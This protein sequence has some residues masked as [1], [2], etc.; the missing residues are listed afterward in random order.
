[1]RVGAWLLVVVASVVASAASCDGP[2]V[3]APSP[4]QP[5]GCITDVSP[6]AHNFTCEG[7]P[8]DVFVPDACQRPGCG[9]ILE[10]HGDTGTG[11]LMD[12]NTNLMALGAQN[13]Y[14]VIAP[15]GPPR[16]D[17]L[18]P[19][20]FPSNDDALVAIVQDFAS[21]FRTDPGR[22]HLTG[23]S[24]GGYVTWRMLCEHA[25]LFA[26]VAPAAGGSAPGGT[27]DGVP[28]VSCPFDASQ[29]AG[30][31]SRQI[32]VLF[33]LG[34]TDYSVPYG[35]TTQIRDQLVA[36]WGLAAPQTL[37][38]DDRYTHARYAGA[39]GAGF[40][41]VYD[42]GY[43]T[44]ADGPLGYQKGHCMP[45]STFDPYAPTYAIP[46]APPNA[47]TWGEEVMKFFL[48][49]PAPPPSPLLS[50]AGTTARN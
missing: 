33:L 34:R 3:P 28:E 50:D 1:M 25:D 21:V 20:W 27:C 2:A 13:G 12:A 15:T 43:E 11:L 39:P 35:C 30:L 19:T 9:I 49:H 7:L 48:A 41:E 5:G 24:R 26:S 8:T 46:C 31:P 45:G 6:G 29:L 37:D 32:P 18:G 22:T 16:T 10:L 36:A 47:F 42:H 14:V 38:G 17:G 40:L 23:F 4:P 44:V